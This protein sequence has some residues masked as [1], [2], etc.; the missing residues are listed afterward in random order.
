M[1]MGAADEPRD[2]SLPDAPTIEQLLTVSTDITDRAVIVRVVGEVDEMTVER[3][4]SAV[5][6]GLREPVGHPVI[7]DMTGV[8]FFG[9]RGMRVLVEATTESDRQDEPL[10]IVVGHQRPVLRPL[11]IAGLDLVLAL[12]ETVDSALS[13]GHDS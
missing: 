1:Y 13:Q 2:D 12:Y 8:T 9:S 3:L 7:V 11:Q 4:R 6:Q 10:R 5:L